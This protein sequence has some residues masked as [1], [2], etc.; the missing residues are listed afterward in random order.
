MSLY[1]E[2]KDRKVIR[3]AAVYLV[4]AWLIVQVVVAISGPLLL[5][6]WFPRAIILVLTA[7]FPF[8]LIVAWAFDVTPAKDSGSSKGKP[9]AIGLIAVTVVFVQF[10]DEHIIN[11]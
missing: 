6:D 7:G 8:A 9:L 2:L 4:V 11:Q 5:P 10:M 3:V 1:S